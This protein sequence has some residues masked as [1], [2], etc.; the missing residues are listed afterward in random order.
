MNDTTIEEYINHLNNRQAS[1]R[2]ELLRYIKSVPNDTNVLHI[3]P[4]YKALNTVFETHNIRFMIESVKAIAKDAYGT[5]LEY[6][7][8]RGDVDFIKQLQRFR[9]VQ[10]IFVIQK[11][12]V[13]E[14]R[15]TDDDAAIEM[16]EL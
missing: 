4:L 8:N 1:K 10:S 13:Q 2:Q 15:F 11:S 14:T 9:T 12:Q 3:K 7:N 16:E 5:L 6:A